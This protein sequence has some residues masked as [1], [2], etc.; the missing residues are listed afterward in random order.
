MTRHIDT[1]SS[2]F[3]LYVRYGREQSSTKLCFY[4]PTRRTENTFLERILVTDLGSIS[5]YVSCSM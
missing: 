2:Q 3:I 4:F 1:D 5:H